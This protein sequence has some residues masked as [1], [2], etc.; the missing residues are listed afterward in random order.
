MGK[1]NQ[2]DQD[3]AQAQNSINNKQYAVDVKE[4]QSWHWGYWGELAALKVEVW[5]EQ[6]LVN[7]AYDIVNG[8]KYG[9]EQVK[10][11]LQE[12]QAKVQE[13]GKSAEN[14]VEKITSFTLKEVG[15]TASGVSKSVELFAVCGFEGGDTTRHSF[16]FDFADG[17][18]GIAKQLE[19]EFLKG[20][21]T[22]A[23]DM[24]TQIKDSVSGM[25]VEMELM[26]ALQDHHRA[27]LVQLGFLKKQITADGE[28]QY[29]HPNPEWTDAR[30]E[31]VVKKILKRK[32]ARAAAKAEL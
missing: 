14:A 8:L 19:E 2:A 23:S 10:D 22:A 6:K 20:I 25:S 32:Q 21:E 28:V 27:D 12:A 29:V 17:I 13:G 26:E 24:L 31:A 3:L 9:F 4:G 30:H 15:F 1:F 16:G 11:T 5:V 18:H 7:L